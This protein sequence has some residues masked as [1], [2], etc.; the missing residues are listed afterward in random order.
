MLVRALNSTGFRNLAPASLEP[1]P[2]F[3]VFAGNNGQGKTNLLEALERKL[4]ARWRRT[5]RDAIATVVVVAMA[6]AGVGLIG[7]GLAQALDV[8]PAVS[9]NEPL[10]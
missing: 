3:N 10:F 1:G 4:V 9:I 2:R 8:G 5:A 7:A 6:L